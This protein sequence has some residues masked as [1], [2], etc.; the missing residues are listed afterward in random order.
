[1]QTKSSESVHVLMRVN[2]LIKAKL[3]LGKI[4]TDALSL[5]KWA[6]QDKT[7]PIPPNTLQIEMNYTDIKESEAETDAKNISDLKAY[8]LWR[9][10]Q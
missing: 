7:C 10:Q 3:H 2:R 4:R 5:F 8:L 6:H 9:E 1:M